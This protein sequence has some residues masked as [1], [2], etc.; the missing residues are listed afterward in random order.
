[1]TMDFSS[2]CS[3]VIC[4]CIVWAKLWMY[5]TRVLSA[6]FTVWKLELIRAKFRLLV[7]EISSKRKFGFNFGWVE[8][9]IKL[10]QLG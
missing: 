3:A 10:T 9:R 7:T 4:P 1:M 2:F 6:E 5:F 8:F